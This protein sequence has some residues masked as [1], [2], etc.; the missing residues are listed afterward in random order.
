MSTTLLCAM[1]IQQALTGPLAHLP[2]DSISTCSKTQCV[3]Y[4]V[5]SEECETVELDKRSV[6]N[7]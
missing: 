3:I 5:E 2:M 4:W 7:R 1:L 6:P